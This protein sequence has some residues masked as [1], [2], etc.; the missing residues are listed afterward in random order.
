MG[1]ISRNSSHNLKFETLGPPYQG[2]ESSRGWRPALAWDLCTAY[3][4]TMDPILPKSAGGVL[5]YSK[6][7]AD[8]GGL[9][10]SRIYVNYKGEEDSPP[11]LP[12]SMTG[13][14][15]KGTAMPSQVSKMTFWSTKF[16][17]LS[18]SHHTKCTEEYWNFAL[19]PA[20]G[21]LQKK[22]SGCMEENF[23]AAT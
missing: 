22:F 10:Y 19:H 20:S 13:V 5:E 8:S 15:K 9:E 1:A 4:R 18:R 3:N 11:P 23:V 12:A 17:P 7:P 14:L 21:V 16:I 2:A 6:M